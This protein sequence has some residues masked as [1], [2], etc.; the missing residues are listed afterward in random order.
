M[1]TPLL[2]VDF[3]GTLTTVDVGDA[4]CE[5]FAD[6]SWLEIDQA[7]VRN[8]ISLPEAQRRMWQLVKATR[9]ALIAH[10]VDVGTLRAGAQ[11][12]FDA[13]RDGRV[14]LVL[15]S[16]GFDAYIDAILGEARECFTALHCNALSFDGDVVTPVFAGGFDC[17]KCAVCKAEIVRRYRASGRSVVFCGD[18]SSDR[19]AAGVADR[20]FAIRGGLL[21]SHCREHGRP[22]IAIDDL[23]QLLQAL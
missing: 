20:T 12:L 11:A 18:G 21:E 19:C 16:G 2:V 8:E 14:E 5:R 4:I 17:A 10:A 23:E 9:E 1:N 7:W 22:V 15:A 3:D 6:P 13:A